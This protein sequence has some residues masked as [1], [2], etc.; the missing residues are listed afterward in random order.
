MA[1]GQN[2]A[3][4]G[5]DDLVFPV[6][7]PTDVVD[8]SVELLDETLHFGAAAHLLPFLDVRRHLARRP[9]RAAPANEIGPTDQ[10]PSGADPRREADE[11]PFTGKAF[12]VVV[13]VVVGTL[14]VGVVVDVVVV[15]AVVVDVVVVDVGAIVVAG[16]PGLLAG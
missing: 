8:E 9:A 10:A 14:D 13:V 5:P 2:A 4:G 7:D 16:E 15:G 6:D 12:E 1:L 3:Q 11:E